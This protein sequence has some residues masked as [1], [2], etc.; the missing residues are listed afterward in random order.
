MAAFLL[1][2]AALGAGLLNYPVAYDR[3]GGIGFATAIQIFTVLLMTTTMTVLVFCAR[4]HNES[5][6][7]GVVRAMCGRK[8]MQLAAGSIAITCFGICV[9]FVIIIGDQFDRIF[10][11]Y[12]GIDFSM[13]FIAALPVIFFAYQTH[14]IVIPVHASMSDR[15]L[16]AFS[17]A[18]GLS[19]IILLFLYCCAG[20][21]GYM[22]YGS[23]V[24]PDVMLMYD[25][26]DPIVVTGIIALVIKMITTYPPV[27]F[28][29]RDTIVRLISKNR[30]KM[31]Y[32]PLD[33]GTRSSSPINFRFNFSVRSYHI[34]ITTIWNIIVL[35]LAIITPNITVAIGFLGSLASCNVFIFPGLAVISLAFRYKKILR[36]NQDEPSSTSTSSSSS[37]SNERT[38]LTSSNVKR[39]PLSLTRKWVQI[40]LA[41]YG[42]FI[43]AMG[44][45][46]FVF[47]LIQVFDDIQNPI[48]HGAVCDPSGSPLQTN[49]S[50]TTVKPIF[51]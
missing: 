33:N 16:H 44:V 35:A 1:I 26:T 43:I 9:T 3:L 17:K 32:Q 15:S 21:F 4:L 7:H 12:I 50:M 47:I 25:A 22:T 38:S 6:Y 11:T 5:S 27:V 24:A 19:M 18:T 28:A 45:V 40:G 20:T 39:S 34:C 36:S 29:G 13:E 48:P 8:V 2:N 10:A 49:H 30:S 14:E 46:M 31:D 51:A 23:N 37:S 41:I 42:V